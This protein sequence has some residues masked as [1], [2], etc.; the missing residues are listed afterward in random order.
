M[1]TYM[2]ECQVGFRKSEEA[3]GLD[4]LRAWLRGHATTDSDIRFESRFDRRTVGLA[5]AVDFRVTRRSE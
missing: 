2:G 1:R 3:I 5:Q 4:Q